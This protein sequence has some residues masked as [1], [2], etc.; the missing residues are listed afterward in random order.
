[1]LRSTHGHIQWPSLGDRTLPIGLELAFSW[2][3]CGTSRG[4]SPDNEVMGCLP[5]E[6]PST[7]VTKSLAQG[8]KNT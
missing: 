4:V 5:A 2:L 7:Q 3:P 1:M 8:S 6:E